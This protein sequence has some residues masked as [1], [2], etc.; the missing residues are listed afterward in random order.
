MITRFFGMYRVKLYHLRRNVKFVIMNSVYHTDKYLQTFYDLKGS[1]VGREA[2]PGQAVK[3]DNDL[4][5]KL[6]ESSLAL[7]PDQRS[8]MRVQIQADCNFLTRMGIMDYSM[9]VGVHHTPVKDNRQK[10]SIATRGFRPRSTSAASRAEMDHDLSSEHS[11]DNRLHGGKIAVPSDRSVEQPAPPQ[12]Q[13][14]GGP[15]HKR[16]PSDGSTNHRL[17]ESIGA[18]FYD[19]GLEEDDSSYLDGTE[20]RTHSEERSF[21][22]ETERKKQ[23][24]IEKLYWPFHRFFDIH[25]HRRVKPVTCAK[26]SSR[27]CNCPDDEH[28]LTGY[29]IPRFIPPLSNR[30]DKGLEL[31]T[32]GQKLPMKLKGP[33]GEECFE[34][35]IFYMGII[36]VLQEYNTRKAIEASYRMMRVN[37]MQASCVA[38]AEYSTRFVNFFDEYTQPIPPTIEGYKEQQEA[39]QSVDSEWARAIGTPKLL[40]ERNSS[41]KKVDDKFRA[42]AS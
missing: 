35:K 40:W 42:A 16:S 11:D 20:G 12:Q 33:N 6:P 15:N 2:K 39:D 31:D 24:T 32:R 7:A 34:G 26:C 27:P 3:K 30:K 23:A 19:N 5:R 17:S 29:A 13:Q 22:M 10:G 37:R 14:H 9:L 28:L 21:S 4:R 36:D 8:K 18:F 1:V 38:P 25:G 41:M